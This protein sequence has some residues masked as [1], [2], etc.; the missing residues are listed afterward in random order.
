VIDKKL[1]PSIAVLPA[2]EEEYDKALQLSRRL[3]IPLAEGKTDKYDLLLL[4]SAQGLAIIQTGNK[5]PGPVMVDLVSPTME[6]RRRH[7][8]GRSQ[9]MAR[10]IGLKGDQQPTIIDATAG[11]GRDAFIL[12]HLGCYVHIIERSQVIGVLLEDGLQRA[13]KSP[14]AAV[15]ISQ[16][17]KLTIGDSRD[18]L[19][20]IKAAERPD[21][22]YLD[23]MYPHRTKS[24]LVKKEMRILRALAG[25]DQDAPSLLETALA[26]ARN[27]VVVKR[28]RL[29]AAI[30]GMPPTTVI[31]SKNSRYDIY[32]IH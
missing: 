28:P 23:P 6:Y 9:P 19:H 1:T 5:N 32:L 13:R 29:A 18:I 3:R 22:I 12:A 20:N 14:E 4:C 17:L 27:R 8:G 21:V 11:L 10:A 30:K 31:T 7:G 2:T 16:R 25:D 15:I 24:S 26:C